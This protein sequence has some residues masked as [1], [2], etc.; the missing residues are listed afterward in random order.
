MDL[1]HILYH[2]AKSVAW[3]TLNRPEALN[4]LNRKLWRGIVETLTRAETDDEIRAVIL[5]G[6][7]R[8]F[9]AGDDIK[10]VLSLKTAEEIRSFFGDF[11]SP[12]LEKILT[13]PKPV[14]A[15]V[16]GLAYGGGCEIVMLCDLAIASEEATFAVPEALI[17]ALP[18]IASVIGTDVIGRLN[19]NH[20]MFTGEPMNA[21]QA[22][23]V[24]LVNEVVSSGE[25]RNAAE[26]LAKKT[27]RAA[28]SS[29]TAMK[30]LANS[31]VQP[32]DL[33]RSVEQLIN[34]LQSEEGKEGHQAFAEK[35]KPRWLN[36]NGAA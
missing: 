6:A 22:K 21:A 16:N 26:T 23:Q 3:I 12:A 13:V 18:P 7:G 2:K 5:T 24:G 10:E 11:A 33:E 4:A 36:P 30:K 31:R 29:I 27:M 20:M 9:S 32:R 14:I 35:R 8:A 19:N 15:A 17:G 25:L 28:P 1:E 34:L